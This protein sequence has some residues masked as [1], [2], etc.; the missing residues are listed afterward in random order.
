VEACADLP[1][2]RET[3]RFYFKLFRY[4]EVAENT[5]A[6][7]AVNVVRDTTRT[8]GFALLAILFR[9][10][11]AVSGNGEA[12]RDEGAIHSDAVVFALDVLSAVIVAAMKHAN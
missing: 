9:F 12:R 4:Q 10:H 7:L 1:V 5:Y 3:R 8:P 6:K 2:R 11:E